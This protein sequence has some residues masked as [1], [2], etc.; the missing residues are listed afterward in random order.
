[1]AAGLLLLAAP[2]FAQN[3]PASAPPADP[4]PPA[5]PDDAV[6]EPSEAPGEAP[7]PPAE[8]PT[9]AAPTQDPPAS[10]PQTILLPPPPPPED[11]L[12][13]PTLNIDRVPPNTSFEFAIQVSYG[14]VA[15]FRDQVPP[16][17]GFGFRAGWGKNFGLH[18]I[19]IAG[20]L[21]A[22]GDIGV[23]TQLMFE[24]ALT[25]DH[26]GRTGLLLGASV[27]PSLVWTSESST[28]EVVYGIDAVP[29]VAA[30]IG[31][32]QTWSRVGRRLFLFA[33]PK[34]R[35]VLGRAS[36]VVAIAV[37]SGGGR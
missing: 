16:W 30:R 29:T 15:Y 26:V 31:W 1:M 37:G 11:D 23:H 14:T 25:W 8:A 17:V 6:G 18:R 32:S 9:S 28:V 4:A 12:P 34:V 22:E 20:G 7:A 36:P 19:G 27:G 24:P 13:I 5:A 2:A 33:E 10:P 3:P 21:I 35:L